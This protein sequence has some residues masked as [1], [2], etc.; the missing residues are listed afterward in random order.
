MRQFLILFV[1]ILFAGC[2]GYSANLPINSQILSDKIELPKSI[3]FEGKEFYKRFETDEFA[4]Y[5][6]KSDPDFGWSELLSVFFIDSSDLKGFKEALDMTYKQQNNT[7]YELKESSQELVEIALYPPIKGSAEFSSF[8]ANTAITRIKKCG[9]VNIKYAKNFTPSENADKIW[10][11]WKRNSGN[12]LK[13]L[14]DIECK[15]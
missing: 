13:N 4:E 11:S 15:N 1:A 2:G 12:I 3:N 14:P 7:K 8:E 5:Y 10:K 9:M 6:L